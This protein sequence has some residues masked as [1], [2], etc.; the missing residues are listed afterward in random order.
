K[1]LPL[2][3]LRNADA[4][5]HVVRAFEDENLPHSEGSIDP[6][7]DVASMETEFILADQIVAEKR[8]EKLALQVQ[9]TNSPE[10]KK[11]LDLFERVVEAL[12]EETPLRNVEFSEAELL[13]LRGYTF[14]SLKPL[15]VVVNAGEAD[16][17]KLDR[18]AAAFGLEE[19]ATHPSTEVV[20]LSARIE[21][22]IAE[23]DE[24]DAASFRADLGITEPALDRMIRASYALLGRISFFT[25]GEDECRAWTI[26]R[27]T[28]ARKAAGAIHTD[29]ER[30]FIRAE[31]IA[32]DHLIAAGTW[33]AGKDNGTLRLEG[34]DY[35][36]A[37]GDVVNFRFNV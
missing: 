26:R 13:T 12:E 28:A 30:G 35:V 1:V 7:R 34:K 25:V 17:G 9:K 10:E 21:A 18:G 37:D 3:Q 4:L 2:D 29:I 5:A 32:Y 27:G 11:E 8:R 19:V 22:E 23:L 20:A 15:L 33:N 14:L 16:A 36:M 6:A 24:E 31:L